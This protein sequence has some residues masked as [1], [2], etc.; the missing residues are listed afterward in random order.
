MCRW[1]GPWGRAGI[2][3]QLAGKA[4]EIEKEEERVARAPGPKG[5]VWFGRK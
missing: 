2:E 1:N 3:N 4:L 5:V